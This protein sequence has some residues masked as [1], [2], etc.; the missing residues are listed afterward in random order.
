MDDV[1]HHV[2]GG[3]FPGNEVAVAPDL[4]GGLDGHGTSESPSI[5]GLRV[6]RISVALPWPGCHLGRCGTDQRSSI[7][8]TE[9]RFGHLTPPDS[10]ACL[11]APSSSLPMRPLGPTTKGSERAF[12][13]RS[14]SDASCSAALGCTARQLRPS[15]VEMSVP[16]GPT[17]I[18]VFVAA[19]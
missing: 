17:V 12:Q 2:D 19:S 13:L 18:Q 3:L 6:Y 14:A 1:A 5:A 16:F 11:S 4:R 9:A 7:A 10:G 8:V 15:S